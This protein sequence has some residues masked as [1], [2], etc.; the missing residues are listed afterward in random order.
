[1]MSNKMI[2]E[3]YN[4]T[5]QRRA[6]EIQEQAAAIR[7]IERPE[8]R[9]SINEAVI[10]LLAETGDYYRLGKAVESGDIPCYK[11]ETGDKKGDPQDMRSY[12]CWDD[13]NKWLEE[14]THIRKFRFPKPADAPAG[15][16]GAKPVTNPSGDD[17]PGKMPKTNIGRLAVKTAWQIECE[18]GRKAT[19]NE[20]IKRLQKMVDKE[21]VLVKTIPHG[22]EWITT[23]LHGKPYNIDACSKTLSTWH[24]SRA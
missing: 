17:I 6:V 22:V 16:D 2:N 14:K 13:L 4:V 24:E 5:E 18:L 10:L 11:H 15:K 12:V 19:V 23:G 7:N 20:V 21:D 8:G 9:Y 3:P 1:M